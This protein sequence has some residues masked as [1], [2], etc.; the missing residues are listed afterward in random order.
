MN[1]EQVTSV[2]EV[3]GSGL[4][5]VGGFAVSL[6]LGLMLVGALALAVS[7]RLSQ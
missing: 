4:F 2:L 6:G 7:W 1:R 5:V 3:A